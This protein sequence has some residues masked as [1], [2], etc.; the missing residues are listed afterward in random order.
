MAE[1][2]RIGK[3]ISR[4]MNIVGSFKIGGVPV[5]ATAAD[6]NTVAGSGSPVNGLTALSGGGQPGATPLTSPICRV[7]T[8]AAA[9]DSVLLPASSPGSQVTVINAAAANSMNVFPATGDAINALSAN[10]AFAVAANKV[11]IFTCAAAGKWN[12]LTTA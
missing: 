2:E 10:A 12:S 7:T 8:V 6:L 3:T 9:G 1:K 4:T 5:S 11:C